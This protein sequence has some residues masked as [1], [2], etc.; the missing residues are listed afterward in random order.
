LNKEK[1]YVHEVL[2]GDWRVSWWKSLLSSNFL[3]ITLRY[4]DK[5]ILEYSTKFTALT[6]KIDLNYLG[7]KLIS[8]LT[9]P[10]ELNSSVV[11]SWALSKA[12]GVEL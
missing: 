3:Q 9:T 8:Q 7:K 2:S 4:K 1:Q 11:K 5:E 12:S 10:N 6:S